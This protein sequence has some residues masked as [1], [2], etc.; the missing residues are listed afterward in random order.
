MRTCVLVKTKYTFKRMWALFSFNTRKTKLL[1][2][3]V[4]CVSNLVYMWG[5]VAPLFPIGVWLFLALVAPV[6][7]KSNYI[8]HFSHARVLHH[9]FSWKHL[10]ARLATIF[11]SLEFLQFESI[12]K[13]NFFS[14]IRNDWLNATEYNTS[15]R[16]RAYMF[17]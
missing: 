1:D 6:I 13:C 2:A 16:K 14:S 7:N 4:L 15:F 11:A 12:I 3:F 5:N 8:N 10:R 17:F 9:T